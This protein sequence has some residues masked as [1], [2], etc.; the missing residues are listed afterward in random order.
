MP[1]TTRPDGTSLMSTVSLRTA[2]LIA[3]ASLAAMAVLSPLGLLV[4]LPAGA[5]G[6]A[7]LVVLIIAALDMV[8]AV[9]LFP[10][11]AG[12]GTLIAGCSAALRLGYGATFATAAGFLVAPADVERFQAIWDLGLFV[13]G[14]HLLL[15]GIAVVR[16]TATPTWIGILVAVAGLGY[17]VDATSVA[18]TP[19]SALTLGQFT[20]IGEVVLLVWLLG[21]AG[22]KRGALTA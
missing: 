9:A 21:W 2:S 13:F 17:L 16:G 22:R 3:G 20:F 7:A 18:L 11:L 4:A 10:V 8:A 12:G 5:V 19:A 1:R 14:A 6:L 15:T